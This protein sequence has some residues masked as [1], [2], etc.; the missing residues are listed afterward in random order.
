MGGDEEL[1]ISF[2]RHLSLF[3]AR[4]ARVGDEE[5]WTS[6]T[7][8]RYAGW[9]A[10]RPAQIA[11]FAIDLRRWLHHVS[12]PVEAPEMA[13]LFGDA[14][15][16]FFERWKR[17]SPVYP[18]DRIHEFRKECLPHVISGK[19]QQDGRKSHV[20]CGDAGILEADGFRS[21]RGEVK[22]KRLCVL[23]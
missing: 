11:I 2:A 20:R 3:T 23:R 10:V 18:A 13:R 22:I 15:L 6:R 19:A 12:E 21:I 17:H 1:L 9:R 16:E 8:P 5:P 4:K 14:L 7:G